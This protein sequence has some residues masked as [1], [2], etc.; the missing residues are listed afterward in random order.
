MGLAWGIILPPPLPQG[1]TEKEYVRCIPP[2][3]L[4]L[5]RSLLRVVGQR[6]D[7]DAPFSAPAQCDAAWA[8]VIE[9]ARSPEG[10]GWADAFDAADLTETR[11][12]Q[13][14]AVVDGQ[15]LGGQLSRDALKRGLP[16]LGFSVDAEA[17][18]SGDW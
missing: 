2:D 3:E 18:G 16:L 10:G 5:V 4:K 11:L 8:R 12:R 1:M 14:A 13:L 7:L 9:A 15:L 17:E 6:R